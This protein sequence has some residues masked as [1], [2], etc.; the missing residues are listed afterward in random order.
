MPN[1]TKDYIVRK[2]TSLQNRAY[3]IRQQQQLQQQAIT[4]TIVLEKGRCVGFTG[5]GSCVG[6][7]GNA[8]GY[9]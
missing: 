9:E 3:G 6:A 8:S 5:A 7:H 2:A 1:S 4:E